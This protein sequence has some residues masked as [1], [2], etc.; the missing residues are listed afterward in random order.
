MTNPVRVLFVHHSVGRGILAHGRVRHWLLNLGDPAAPELFDHDYNR[1]GLT[2]PDG[3]K[4]G[5]ALPIPDDNTDPPG[6]QKLFETAQR[7]ASLR[8]ELKRYDLV[9]V[10]SCFP[11]S[12]IESDGALETMKD[13]YRAMIAAAADLEVPLAMATTPP[14][15]IGRIE[16][17]SATRAAMVAG[18]L[19]ARDD[20]VAV[21]DLF[22]MLADADPESPTYGMLR[23]AYTNPFLIDSH[24]TRAASRAIGRPFAEFLLATAKLA[25]ARN[26]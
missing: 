6:L 14:V 12:R 1:R 26:S 2:G 17:H 10:K 7:E 4:L 25:E 15:R 18:W 20:L 21:F 13:T 5:R 24:P 16:Q 19:T 9:V 11:N 23:K 22:G 8:S 3:T